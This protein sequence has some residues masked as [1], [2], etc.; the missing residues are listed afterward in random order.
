MQAAKRPATSLQRH[1]N[2]LNAYQTHQNINQ[3]SR[4]ALQPLEVSTQLPTS[5]GTCGAMVDRVRELQRPPDSKPGQTSDAK[6]RATYLESVM[7]VRASA[8]PPARSPARSLAPPRILC[9]FSRQLNSVQNLDDEDSISPTVDHFINQVY[10]APVVTTSD[11]ESLSVTMRSP[12][13]R[14]AAMRSAR[15]PT[16][17]TE[18]E[19][20]NWRCWQGPKFFR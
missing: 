16:S 3:A 15:A 1:T 17:A 7:Q 20:Q 12:P 11:A 4:L 10:G 6:R 8:R 9:R 18:D 2:R 19:I 14:G 5:D 13:A